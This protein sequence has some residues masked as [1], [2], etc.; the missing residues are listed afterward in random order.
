MA[1]MQFGP[2]RA[3]TMTIANARTNAT[4]TIHQASGVV[5][6]ACA[7][8]VTPTTV[9]VAAAGTIATLVVVDEGGSTCSW[10]VVSNAPFLSVG[11]ITHT[12]DT[13]SEVSV[14][15]GPNNGAARAGTLSIVNPRMTVTVTVTQAGS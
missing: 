11:T 6:T 2:A 9:S 4:V 12:S 3:G 15:V 8:T 1:V 14:A 13:R 10:D 5:G 7:F